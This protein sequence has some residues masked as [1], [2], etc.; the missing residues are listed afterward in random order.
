MTFANLDC[1]CLDTAEEIYWK[2][3]EVL[4]QIAQQALMFTDTPEVLSQI[5]QIAQIDF[6]ITDSQQS[7][8]IDKTQPD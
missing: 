3:Q 6:I 1:Y 2:G 4:A 5:A 8:T 7:A